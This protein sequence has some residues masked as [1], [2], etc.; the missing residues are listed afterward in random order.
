MP[1]HVDNPRSAL[2]LGRAAACLALV[3]VVGCASRSGPV[4]AP[5]RESGALEEGRWDRTVQ[6]M[7]RAA[8]GASGKLFD[9]AVERAAD[10]AVRNV[11]GE[12]YPFDAWGRI[13]S[14]AGDVLVVAH[15]RRGPL[16]EAVV[17]RLGLVVGDSQPVLLRETSGEELG[18]LGA[19]VLVWRPEWVDGAPVPE[20][21]DGIG[22]SVVLV[23]LFAPRVGDEVWR[24]DA[25][26]AAPG[27]AEARVATRYLL[28]ARA[29]GRL[30]D[31]ASLAATEGLALTDEG[32]RRL[33]IAD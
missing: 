32:W 4:S 33:A 1:G 25:L 22:T 2:R 23:D 10:E 26:V 28:G 3:L 17:R 11:L 31:A 20:L 12:A 8:R 18:E 9:S 27:P 14:A 29:L 30:P 24:A 16:A 13:A 21:P 15:P 7:H 19:R 5:A 6:L